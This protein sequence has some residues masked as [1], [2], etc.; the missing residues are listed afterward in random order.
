MTYPR[1]LGLISLLVHFA[2]SPDP[3][4]E[5]SET[6][7]DTASAS[8]GSGGDEGDLLEWAIT[9]DGCGHA[10]GVAPR[11]D[12]SVI[13]GEV[14]GVP[15]AIRVDKAG[16]VIWTRA[17][18]P[19][20]SLYAIHEQTEGF[21][22]AGDAADD[23]GAVIA[24]DDDGEVLTQIAGIGVAPAGLFGVAGISGTGDFAVTGY[25]D[26]SDLLVQRFSVDGVGAPAWDAP[27]GGYAPAI[28]FAARAH[29]SGVAVCG[30]SPALECGR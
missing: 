26:N 17:Y 14:D 21:L 4:L 29:P 5:S 28:G 7:S 11:G 23:T 1:L 22:L 13:I 20:V 10:Y 27:S 18:A 6:Q 2:C 25:T 19:D 15:T 24:I 8:T 3:G 16:A 9:L 30:R 12:D